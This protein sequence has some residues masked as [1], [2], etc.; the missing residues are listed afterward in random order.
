MANVSV[1]VCMS[2]TCRLA[3]GEAVLAEIE[4][5][6]ATNAAVGVDTVTVEASGCLGNCSRAPNAL[7]VRHGAHRVEE[8][9]MFERLHSLSD[10]E[11]VALSAL[12]CPQLAP[13]SA[14]ATGKLVQ[15]RA[16]RMRI[17][18]VRELR[19]NTAAKL[20]CAASAGGDDNMQALFESAQIL[21]AGAA[22]QLAYDVLLRVSAVLPD[23]PVVTQHTA[24]A[25]ANLGRPQEACDL[26]A[27][28]IQRLP[29]RASSGLKS[30]M[31]DGL[32]RARS[33]LAVLSRGGAAAA[34]LIADATVPKGYARWRLERVQLASPWSA[35]YHFKREGKPAPNGSAAAIPLLWHTTLLAQVGENNEGPLGYIE[36]DYTPI[37][38]AE[39][40][41]AGVC[42][43]LVRVY[44]AGKATQWLLHEA[45][46]T[47]GCS[48]LLSRPAQTMSLSIVRPSSIL[49]LVAGTGV[50][51]AQQLLALRKWRGEVPL[52]AIY[53]CRADDALMLR[54]LDAAVGSWTAPARLRV[55]VTP[56]NAAGETSSFVVADELLGSATCDAA[57]TAAFPHVLFAPGRVTHMLL[58]EELGALRCAADDAN[59]NPSTGTPC[60]VV[61]GPQ[62]FNDAQLALLLA[63][64]VERAHIT[65]L[66][67]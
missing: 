31:N 62:G 25:L 34:V 1:H 29:R 60:V 22:H 9:T 41:R 21:T 55:Q 28:A 10:S 32:L 66:E 38:N 40:W 27:A 6:C 26:M 54:E 56:P 24:A 16:V 4:E 47:G 50:V 33:V 48:V 59:R 51:V 64:G 36:R 57:F 5:L 42:R 3:G 43:L 61:S 11:E 19:W 20:A 65:V 8:E 58:R 14:D 63:A 37:S 53:S 45:A 15:A 17:A 39:E 23:E 44:A 67:A 7:L 52:T 13:L 35:V 49:L 46:R 2:G 30:F 18:A 12:R